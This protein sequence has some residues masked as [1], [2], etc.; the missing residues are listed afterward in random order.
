[1]HTLITPDRRRR[2]FGY[3]T[4]AGRN[5]KKSSFSKKLNFFF[6]LRPMRTTKLVAGQYYHIYNRGVNRQPIFFCADNWAFFVR[7][8]RQYFKAELVE[9]VAYCLMP[10]HYHLLVYIKCDDAGLE[11]MQPFTVAYTKAVNKQQQRSGH[12]FQGPFEAKHVN[13]DAYL[14][15]LTRYIHL[16]PVAAG[17]VAAPADWVYSSYR[18]YVGLRQG[19]LPMPDIVLSQFPS[20]QAYRRSV[21]DKA[22]L[23]PT[24]LVLIHRQPAPSVTYRWQPRAQSEKPTRRRRMV[25]LV[26][27]QGGVQT[28]F[29]GNAVVR[30]GNKGSIWDRNG[31]LH[32]RFL[33][34]LCRASDATLAVTCRTRQT[35]YSSLT[36]RWMAPNAGAN[37]RKTKNSKNA[38]IAARRKHIPLRT[39][40]WLMKQPARLSTLV[41]PNRVPSTTFCQA[42]E[43]WSS[44]PSPMLSTVTSS[45]TCSA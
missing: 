30:L 8:V 17:L 18:E 44:T 13:R 42:S 15:R 37:D 26:Q 38:P 1:M 40:S 24:H 11:I 23:P 5:Q 35:Q 31:D 14:K 21:A 20:V 10:N 25:Y 2:F 3:S 6:Q 27:Y 32:G 12:L 7:K 19:T 45:K 28:N 41:R 4:R 39:S 16:N 9:I 33:L 43:L 36:W 34:C 29:A 22:P